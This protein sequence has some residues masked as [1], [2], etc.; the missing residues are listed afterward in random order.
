MLRKLQNRLKLLRASARRSVGAHA[1]KS[2]EDAEI[3]AVLK[4]YR[5]KLTGGAAGGVHSAQVRLGKRRAAKHKSRTVLKSFSKGNRPNFPLPLLAASR[6]KDNKLACGLKPDR[7]ARWVPVVRRRPG[8]R[9]EQIVLE[10]FSFIDHPQ[11]TLNKIL[12]ILDFECNAVDAQLHFDDQYCVDVAAYLV[13][14]EMWQSLS[15]VFRKGR[16]TVPIQKVVEALGLRRELSMKFPGL[17]NVDNVWAFPKRSRRPTGS[18]RAVNRQLQPQSRE[19]VADE[20]CNTLDQWLDT[21]AQDLELTDQGKSKFAQII[22]ELL[23]NAERHSDAPRKD[24]S[25]STAA[26]MAKRVEGDKDVFRCHMGFL[27]VGASLAESLATAPIK[28]R[29]QV[30]KYCDLHPSC[31][32]S[33][34]TLSTLVALQDGITRDEAAA[35]NERGGVGLQDVLELINVLGVTHT[36]GQEPRM[37]IVSGRSCIRIRAP[38]LKGAR[39]DENGPRVLWFNEQNDPSVAPDS[40]YVFDLETKFPGTIIGLTFVLSKEDLMAVV[41]AED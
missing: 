32:I 2:S 17:E 19:K 23:D 4:L 41:N 7:R 24:G 39:S 8:L 12:E 10:N 13:L 18:S 30:N 22:G 1:Q 21:A 38:Y 9:Y 35:A 15:R 28:I 29:A 36:G 14:A 37:T 40:D 20:F 31:G 33:R 16:M 25:W 34:D 26:F 11:H 5:A 3:R 6:Y 27:S